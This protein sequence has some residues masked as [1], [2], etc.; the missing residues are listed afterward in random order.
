[1]P[2]KTLF[3]DLGGVLVDFCHQKM[4][5]NLSAICGIE[6]EKIFSLLFESGLGEAYERGTVSTDEIRME[7]EAQAITPF[8][9]EAFEKACCAIFSKKMEMEHLL[10]QLKEKE[11]ELILLSNTC[12]VHFAYIQS[13]Y[14]LLSLFDSHILS[15]E[16]GARK[17]EP[18]IFQTALKRASSS[19]ENCFYIDDI[20]KY[21]EAAS[22]IGIRGHHFTSLE[23]LLPPL[24]EFLGKRL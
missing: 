19:K 3:F 18:L 12:A 2:S 5:R 22:Q 23:T 21:I 7:L 13:S 14:S 15:F 11:V 8:S 17:P 1:M 16:V 20:K 10:H 24:E 6:A 4:C 9:L